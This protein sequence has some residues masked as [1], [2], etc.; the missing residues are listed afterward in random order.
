[1][2]ALE[3]TYQRETIP[4]LRKIVDAVVQSR[5]LTISQSNSSKIASSEK[6]NELLDAYEQWTPAEVYAL[7]PFKSL[8]DTY[9]RDDY[10]RLYQWERQMRQHTDDSKEMNGWANAIIDALCE[11]LWPKRRMM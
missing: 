5:S 6:R 2:I 10:D 9:P 1:M 3:K 4:G 8:L 11:Q 7:C